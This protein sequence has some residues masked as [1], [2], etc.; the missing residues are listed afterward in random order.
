MA[1]A[2][3]SGRG[4][5][6]FESPYSDFLNGRLAQS[7]RALR[8][9]RKSQ[10]FKSAVVHVK[11]KFVYVIFDENGKPR[12]IG[13]TI[14]LKDRLYTHWKE[15]K[16][17]DTP[18]G[19]WLLT[20][21]QR[22]DAWILDEV[23]YDCWTESEEYWIKFFRQVGADLLNITDRHG[24]QFRG[25]HHTDETKKILGQ[26]KLGNQYGKLGQKKGWPNDVI[27]Q[28]RRECPVCGLISAPGP[29]G[30]HRKKLNH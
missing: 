3:R 8:S 29:L 24:T 17:R 20:L 27:Q 30:Y 13:C 19:R 6:A 28:I 15:R 4:G 9:Q 2:P 11:N 26:Q 10:R 22:P 7:G 18:L 5:Q 14:N 16:Y 25:R 21:D 23:P 1:S 12:Y